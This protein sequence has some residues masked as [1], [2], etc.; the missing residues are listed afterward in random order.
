MTAIRKNTRTLT[1]FACVFLERRYTASRRGS[2]VLRNSEN[3]KGVFMP[4][5]P[6][7][8]RSF[9]GTHA[10]RIHIGR[11]H[12]SEAAEAG[13]TR[14]RAKRG[15]RRTATAAVAASASTGPNL[16]R[17]ATT[18]L[19]AELARRASSLDKVRSI[20]SGT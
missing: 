18:D 6:H 8:S 17:V 10:L 9:N 20:I 3:V 7:C 4:S 1:L 11:A 15:R 16:S 19:V 5:C 13:G 12:K 2:P 14:K